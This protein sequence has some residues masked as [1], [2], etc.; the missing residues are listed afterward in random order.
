MVISGREEMCVLTGH[1]G[2]EVL[3]EGSFEEL[4][5]PP[6]GNCSINTHR[7]LSGWSTLTV[8]TGST[9]RVACTGLVSKETCPAEIEPGV[10]LTERPI[11]LK[12]IETDGAIVTS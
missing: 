7:R 8:Y 1:S 6:L 11:L 4:V 9:L 2:L 12:G 10:N 5:R 3:G